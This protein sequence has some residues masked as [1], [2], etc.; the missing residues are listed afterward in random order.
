M[1]VKIMMVLEATAGGS[2]RH[3]IELARG[4]QR[5][6]FDVHLVC[7]IRRNAEFRSTLCELEE[8]GLTVH[9]LDMLRELHPLHDAAAALRLRRLVLT[10]NPQVLHL[11][12]SKAGGLGRSAVL[13]LG[14]RAPRV[15]YTPHAFAF[16][17]CEG[18]LNRWVYRCLETAL[19]PWTDEIVAVSESEGQAALGLS[20]RRVSVI[21]NGVNATNTS[22][23]Y[24]RAP[25]PLRIGWLGRL[26]WQKNPEGAVK[27]SQ[28]LFSQRVDHEL[29][30]GGINE[31]DLPEENLKQASG[32]AVRTLGF[33]RDTDAFHAGIDIFLMTSRCEGLPYSGLDAMSHGR[34][35]VGFDVPGVKDLVE[36]GVTGLLAP[37][38]DF[39]L[40]AANIA[41]LARDAKLR[42]AL[43]VAAQHRVRRKFQ[44]EAQLDRL[45]D[46]YRLL[47]STGK[48]HDPE[49]R[50]HVIQPCPHS[51]FTE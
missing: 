23:A 38:G 51:Y 49:T 5:R 30:L 31:T 26:G 8:T 33:V 41:R 10:I 17:A 15:I 19:I 12:S 18:G 34:P 50:K 40:L 32:H 37:R 47:A 44:L 29:L 28:A 14:R 27:T 24:V 35:I 48:V 46:L 11:H 42:E 6:G 13:G 22:S 1:S 43:G 21:P 7:G 39:R 16:L 4:C 45:G 9:E 20:A 3:V 36:H 2:A 25:G